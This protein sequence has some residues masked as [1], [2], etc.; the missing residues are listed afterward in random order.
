MAQR[1]AKS[2]EMG[3]DG[4]GDINKVKAKVIP[5]NQ[6]KI[7]VNNQN[8]TPGKKLYV[9]GSTTSLIL[10]G[11]FKAEIKLLAEQTCKQTQA[12]FFVLEEKGKSL[13][14]MNTAIELGILRL[15]PEQPD[16]VHN[17]ENLRQRYPK[18]FTGHELKKVLASTETLGYFKIGAKTQIIADSSPVGLG[19]VLVPEDEP[20]ERRIIS[21]ASRSLTAVERRY[22]QTENE[23][24]ALV[25]ARER[26]HMYIYG[27][28]FKLV[29]DHK[30]LQYIFSDKSRPCARVERWVLRLQP[31]TYTVKHISGVKNIADSLSR[32]LVKEEVK[33]LRRDKT[34][35][36]KFT[37]DSSIPTA[38]KTEEIEEESHKDADL[39][40]IRECLLSGK[41]EKLHNTNYLLIKDELCCVR[42]IVLRGTRLVMPTSLRGRILELG[43][44]GHPGIVLMKQ[45]PSENQ[46]M[47]AQNGQRS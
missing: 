44:E 36:V 41:W 26:F 8:K 7:K 6:S 42:N 21:Y 47:G 43:H 40:N 9:Y 33:Q 14:S 34:E 5:R 23:A 10:M 46:S 12:E 28:K 25:W 37:V 24:L 32:L 20:N 15:E 22:S 45:R 3:G 13:L 27:I 1:A 11:S 2:M 39:Q 16:T 19:A 4:K 31:Y 17:V 29:T 38:T 18:L 30:P 35:Y